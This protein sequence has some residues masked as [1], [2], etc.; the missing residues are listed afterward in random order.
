[1]KI[2]QINST[3][4]Y[5]STGRIAEEIGNIVLSNGGESYIA[6]G[7]NI[8]KSNSKLIK[9]GN[10]LDQLFHLL[11]S[12]IFGNSGF[13][14]HYYTNK[15]IR[16]I[17]K[18]NPDLIHL[19]NI[20]GYYLNIEILFNF[21]AKYNKPI[22]WTL[23]DCWSFTGHCCH[24][25]RVNCTKWQ[26]Q[27]EKCPLIQFYPRSYFLDNSFENF[28]RKKSIFNKPRNLT[29]VTVSKWLKDEFEKSYLKKYDANVIYNG[30]DLEVFK[31]Q[32]QFLLKK[33]YGYTEKKI[34][35]GVANVW[36]DLKGLNDFIKLSDI[37]DDNT[38]IILIGLTNKQINKL[39]K[40]IHGINRTANQLE[41]AAYYSMADVFICPSIAE[42]FGLVIAEAIACG[43]PAIVY[44]SSAMPE[45]IPEGIGYVV[46][47]GDINA[48]LLRSKAI[49]N[50]KKIDY[51]ECCRD[52]AL[53]NF[54]KKINYEK[55]YQ[56]YK[57]KISS[58]I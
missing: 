34:F 37:I 26:T 28:S 3:V 52:F 54:D 14:S 45:L 20:H 39:P 44:N 1:M 6:F 56:L 50:K 30:V 55:Y 32:D 51:I 13:Y 5:G 53:K 48:I 16:Q 38:I 46:E 19:H 40:N 43:T 47:R 31:P 12:R 58:K 57:K 11:F 41:L 10:K 25:T 15:F 7:R 8:N 22:I 24:Y 33:K 23:H 36:S 29:I 18:L 4:N 2:L 35:L 17:S 49:L 21:L 27:C 9:I 42:T